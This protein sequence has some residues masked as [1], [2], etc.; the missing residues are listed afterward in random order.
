MWVVLL[1]AFLLLSPTR[2]ICAEGLGQIEVLGQ[3]STNPYDLDSTANPFGAGSPFNPNGINNPFSP[4]GSPFSD[5]SA[6]NPYA[7]DAPKLYDQQGNYRGKLS[8]NPYDPDSTSNPYGHY[9][10]P[11]SP[12]SI[13]N[14]YGV[15]SPYRS[16]SPTNPYGHGLRIDGRY[17]IP[18]I[19]L[20]ESSSLVL[21][22]KGL[23]ISCGSQIR[24]RPSGLHLRGAHFVPG[25]LSLPPRGLLRPSGGFR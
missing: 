7:T 3:L 5:R 14:P 19:H 9:G 20:P 25:T 10:S 13:N 15:G 21:H 16:D 23:E 17:E 11:Y 4:Y 2:T 1:I 12:D 24:H 6:T 8:A 22:A 18:S